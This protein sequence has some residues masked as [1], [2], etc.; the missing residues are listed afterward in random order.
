MSEPVV[1]RGRFVPGLLFG[2]VLFAG[3][4]IGLSWVYFAED[5]NPPLLVMAVII[6]LVGLLFLYLCAAAYSSS[7]LVTEAGI[8]Q[9]RFTRGFTEIRWDD[10]EQAEEQPGIEH[11]LL[12]LKLQSSAGRRIEV[13]S[14]WMS[15]YDGF[16]DDVSRYVQ[17]DTSLSRADGTQRAR[18]E[19]EP[20]EASARPRVDAPPDPRSL[21][22]RVTGTQ[23]AYVVA[24]LGMTALMFWRAFG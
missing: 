23:V 13:Y 14:N 7:F 10:L 24:T 18:A 8:V 20:E 11:G 1:V 3:A 5:G 9:T 17:I 6:F 15:D 22:L 2:G 16:F 12:I 19:P 21:R 4:G